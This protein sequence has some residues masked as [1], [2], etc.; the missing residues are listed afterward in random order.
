MTVP[1]QD[2]VIDERNEL[3]ARIER[4]EAFL[5]GP[6]A[7]SLENRVVRLLTRQRAAMMEYRRILDERIEE[8][9]E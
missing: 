5:D 8:F 4:L 2:R 3:A 7:Q 6:N 1:Y 9:P